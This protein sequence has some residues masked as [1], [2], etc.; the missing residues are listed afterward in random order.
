MF[1]LLLLVRLFVPCA[2]TNNGAISAAVTAFVKCSKVP[3]LF[4]GDFNCKEPF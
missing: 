3:T 2:I 4:G 1:P